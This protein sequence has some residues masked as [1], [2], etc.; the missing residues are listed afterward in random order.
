MTDGSEKINIGEP[1]TVDF[2]NHPDEKA[3]YGLEVQDPPTGVRKPRAAPVSNA[4]RQ[5]PAATH[6]I[7]DLTK[8]IMEAGGGHPPPPPPPG[9][10]GGVGV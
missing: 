9:C 2:T 5:A 10:P 3:H 7:E 4:L 1:I 6:V 8:A